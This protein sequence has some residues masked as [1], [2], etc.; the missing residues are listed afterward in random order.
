[1][2]PPLTVVLVNNAG[3]GIFSFLPVAE[4]VPPEAFAQLWSTPQNVDLAGTPPDTFSQL[5]STPQNVDLAGTPPR[6]CT[7]ETVA[8]HAQKAAH[9]HRLAFLVAPARPVEGQLPFSGSCCTLL[10]RS[11]LG[12][13][14]C[15][16][17]KR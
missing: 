1:M 17:L 9:H 8:A 2:R 11:S 4:Q 13:T 7:G 14:S 16:H 12:N 10:L 5:W 15:A 3:G 6:P